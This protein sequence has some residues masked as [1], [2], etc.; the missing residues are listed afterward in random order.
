MLENFLY[1]VFHIIR[2][3]EKSLAYTRES[4]DVALACMFVVGRMRDMLRAQQMYRV[5]VVYVGLRALLLAR[6]YNCA[7]HVLQQRLG[8][9][10]FQ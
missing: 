10:I 9:P 4:S 3:T 1:I 8:P 2:F 7:Q 5:A 6:V